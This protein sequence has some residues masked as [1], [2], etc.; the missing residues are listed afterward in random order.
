MINEIMY[1]PIS[2]DNS[3][4]Y[5]ELY[6]RSA[7][8][9]SLDGW[10]FTAGID[11]TFPSNMVIA[12]GGY[13]VVAKN[14]AHLLTNYANLNANNTAG[15]F[16]GG[17]RNSGE[18]LALSK[19]EQVISTN[20]SGV[21]K[22]NTNYIVMDEVSCLNGGRWGNW[23]D[24]GGSSLELI[25]SRADGRLAA[26]WAD[27]DETA[28]SAWTVVNVSGNMDN[29]TGTN[30]SVQIYMQDAGECLVDDVQVFNSGGPNLVPNSDFEA[31]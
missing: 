11:F 17:L 2:G 27:S 1:K 8:A 23:S 31:V 15:D 16:G 25:D 20:M 18:R 30:N 3:D 22:T 14:A 5:V 6:N 13:M 12:A 26:N 9:V 24:G 7:G 4:E 19:P 10:Q 28:K 21:V 29:G